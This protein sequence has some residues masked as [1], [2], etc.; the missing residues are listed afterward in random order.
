MRTLNTFIVV[1]YGWGYFICVKKGLLNY[2]LI[3]L[4]DRGLDIICFNRHIKMVLFELYF[5]KID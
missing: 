3:D 1:F 5:L 4:F 2:I